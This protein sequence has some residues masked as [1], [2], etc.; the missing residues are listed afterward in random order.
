[1]VNKQYDLFFAFFLF[2][3]VVEENYPTTVDLLLVEKE[4]DGLFQGHYVFIPQFGRL[5]GKSG[6]GK[7][8]ICEYCMQPIAETNTSY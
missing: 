8:S 2:Y 1:M 3:Y 7:M 6:H 5:I 4:I